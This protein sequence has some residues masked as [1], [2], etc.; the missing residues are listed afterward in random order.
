M[1]KHKV[2]KPKEW[3]GVGKPKWAHAK[4]DGHRIT[5]FK[6]SNGSCVALTTTGHDISVQLRQWNWWSRYLRF[7]PVYTSVDCELHVP[8][9]PAS[10]IKTALKEKWQSLRLTPF[11]VPIHRGVS[12]ELRRLEYVEDQC[13]TWGLNFIPYHKYDSKRDYSLKGE[14]EGWVLKEHNYSGWWKIKP[15]KTLDLVVIGFNDGNG[16]NLGLV[17]SLRCAIWSRLATNCQ[18]PDKTRSEPSLTALEDFKPGFWLREIASV[19]GLTDSCRVDIDEEKDFGRVCE[20][21]YQY[22]GSKGRLRH[23][24][25]IRWR[26]DKKTKDANVMP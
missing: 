19:G 21:A 26:D 18:S 16:R 22:V 24:R 1:W 14:Y 5:I 11:A 2:L 7:V 17:G 20:V 13:T 3:K 6:Q 15:V 25:F 10:C 9:K 4:L 23:P 12:Q 8:G